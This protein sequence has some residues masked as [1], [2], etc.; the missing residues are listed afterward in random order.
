MKLQKELLLSIGLLSMT[1]TAP[2][3]AAPVNVNQA[4]AKVIAQNLTGIGMVKAQRIVDYCAKE[5]CDQAEDLMSVK[6][7]GSKT[8]E[9]NRENL[10]FSNDVSMTQAD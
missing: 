10:R 5:H 8:I 2:A 6:G 1:I 4:T 7:V 3:S 9:K